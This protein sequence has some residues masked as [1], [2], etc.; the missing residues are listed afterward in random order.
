MA[1][2]RNATRY[3][4]GD[5]FAVRIDRIVPG[6]AGLGRGPN[7]AVFVE[8]AAP[9]DLL[10]IEIVSV[11]GGAAHGRIVSVREASTGRIDPPCPWYGRCGGCDLQHLSYPAQLDA[12]EAIVRDALDRIGGIRWGGEIAR[13]GA[14]RP[15]GAR[16]RVELH[17][18]LATGSLGFFERRSHRVVDV[19][20]CL[21]SSDAINQAIS[22]LRRSTSALPVSVHLLAGNGEVHGFPAIP[23]IEDG[24]FWLDLAG[25][26]Y[27][28]DPGGFF[29]SSFDLL[30]EL[31]AFVTG[32][33]GEERTIA[34]DLF[35]GV[36]LFSL[37]LARVFTR[38]AGVE[39]DARAVR[40]AREGAERNGIRNARFVVDDAARW[41]NYRQQIRARPDLVV[42]DPPRTGLDRS[43]ARL[44]AEKHLARFTYVSCEPAT[45]ARDLR[46]LS[47]GNLR[48]DRIAIFDLF[49]QTHH[50][51]T[52]VRMV[53]CAQPGR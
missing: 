40:H 50:V 52:V 36:G 15:F 49:P 5:R 12:K 39:S 46:I 41:V 9:G 24:A 19:P 28:V 53:D 44:L 4:V 29:Q 26:A 25:T 6:G 51:E 2:T 18:D 45:L 11:H 47:A 32:S 42:V 16:T 8:Y 3:A 27:S 33:A 13:F 43:L 31:I 21:A 20:S 35:S 14:P 30:S 10:E 7:G 48:I 34:W 23:P 37:P 22:A 38:V 17:H 1:N